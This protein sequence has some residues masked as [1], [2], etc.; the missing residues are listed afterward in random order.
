MLQEAQSLGR[1]NANKHVVMIPCGNSTGGKQELPF[2]RPSAPE[3]AVI[4]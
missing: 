3:L 2:H 1:R 4:Y